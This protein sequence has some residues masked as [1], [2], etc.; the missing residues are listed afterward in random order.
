MGRKTWDSLPET[1]RPLIARRN[2]VVTGQVGKT[3]F[4]AETAHSFKTALAL[5]KPYAPW[6]NVWVIG[7]AQ[8]Y[9]EAMPFADSIYVTEIDEDFRGDTFAPE[10]PSYFGVVAH[11]TAVCEKSGLSLAFKTYERFARES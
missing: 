1:S 4:C 3:F 10:I 9:R 5:V 11:E 6:N 8:I 7:G 2:I